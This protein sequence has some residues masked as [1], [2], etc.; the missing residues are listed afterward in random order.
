MS[1][2]GVSNAEAQNDVHIDTETSE[3]NVTND[4]TNDI[5]NPSLT[6]DLL[7]SD[8]GNDSLSYLV[9]FMTTMKVTNFTF[10][11]VATTNVTSFNMTPAFTLSTT[12]GRFI[13]LKI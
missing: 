6:D 3:E 12:P 11:V 8:T 5:N 2:F 7:T 10:P 4:V 9:P 1:K 13:P